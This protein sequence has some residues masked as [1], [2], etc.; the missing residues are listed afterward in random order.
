MLNITFEKFQLSKYADCPIVTDGKIASLYG[1]KGSNVYVLPRGERAKS[2]KQAELLCKWFLSRNLNKSDVVVA[3]GGGSVGDTVGFATSIYKR[4]VKLLHV[5][6]TLIAQI[7]SS[8]GGKTALNVDGVKNAVGSYH[9]ADTLIDVDFLNTLDKK[10]LTSGYG[11]LLKFRMLSDE[12]DQVYQT[13][14]LSQTIRACV[15]Y[16]QQLCVIDPYCEGARNKLNF[17]HTIGH[18][19]ELK[20]GIP[21][22]VA[23]ANGI[24]YETML[25]VNMGICSRDYAEKWTAEV[26]CNFTVYPLNKE[27][28]L[29]T[30]QDKKNTDGKVNFVLPEAFTEASFTIEELEDLQHA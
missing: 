20:Y 26:K 29:L 28:L 25:A 1:I 11:E 3:V 12:I 7:D 24:Y 27:I 16:K 18:A 13:G 15:Q 22:G 9:F 5:P 6:T 2:F 30:R 19:M 14:D 10:Q 23:V 8:I 4:G 21:H 17:G